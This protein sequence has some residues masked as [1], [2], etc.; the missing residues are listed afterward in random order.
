MSIVCCHCCSCR[1]L[2]HIG[3]IV[4]SANTSSTTRCLYSIS[5]IRTVGH[6]SCLP[7]RLPGCLS[8]DTL[9][10]A[11]CKG[12]VA[13]NANPP[14]P[15]PSPPLQI[16]QI[17]MR[18]HNALERVFTSPPLHSPLH[19]C[20]SLCPFPYNWKLCHAPKR[21]GSGEGAG[22]RAEGLTSGIC[23]RHYLTPVL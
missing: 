13:S 11:C 20:I 4:D 10:Y 18:T 17:H 1:F 23:C 14:P 7:G 22:Q 16:E 9:L 12:S 8:C 6:P 3:V 21:S 19:S 15:P 2:W 5:I